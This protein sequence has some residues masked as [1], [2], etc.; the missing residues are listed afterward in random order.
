MKGKQWLEHDK[1]NAVG[2]T[3]LLGYG[4]C[5]EAINH[6]DVL[7]M[8]GTDFPFA[9]FL[10]HAKVKT[11]QV[12]RDARHLGRR[13]PLELG[14]TGDVQATVAALLPMVQEKPGDTFLREHDTKTE[15]FGE[16]LQHY[17]TKGPLRSSAS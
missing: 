5:W 7:L 14:V 9:E 3:G 12:D 4:G 2:M 17:V 8:L 11:I 10:P 6:C 13:A 1:P 15:R 16:T